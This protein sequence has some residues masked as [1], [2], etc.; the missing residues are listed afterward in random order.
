MSDMNVGLIGCGVMGGSL[1][2]ALEQV[3]Q[4]ALVAVFDPDAEAAR[5][6]AAERGVQA[7]S[8]LETMLSREDIR[9]VIIAAPPFLHRELCVAAS[10]AG[11][12]VF[13]EKP[14]APTVADCDEIIAA[15]ERA[16]VKLMV[17]QVCRYHAIHGG[18]KRIVDSGDVGDPIFMQVARTGGPWSG[19]WA[20]SWRASRE[21]SGGILMEIN[22]HEIDFMLYVC[23]KATSVFASGGRYVS[24][25]LDYPD[26]AAVTLQ[27]ESG[28]TGFLH[29]S[30]ASALGGYGGH[31]DGTE[32]AIRFPA[33]FMED[34]EV[35]LKRF[36]GEQETRPLQDPGNPVAAELAAWVGAVLNDHEPEVTGMDGR[37]VVEVAEAAYES[38][39]SG[40]PV[41]IG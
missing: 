29:S 12:H 36:D 26:V 31:L 41:T 17:G 32:G 18:V 33:L 23:G 13:V 24:T 14:L 10:E 3:E 1:S 37:A 22:A 4:A 15:A 20:K 11:K 2:G 9:G 38:I 8:A 7:E 40:R 6:V 27:F 5:Q 35:K 19:V 16:G 21:K 30:M 34:P 25:D 28:A 39:E